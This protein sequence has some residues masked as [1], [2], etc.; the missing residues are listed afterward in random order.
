MKSTFLLALITLL[1]FALTSCS[2][3]APSS[4][5]TGPTL[6]TTSPPV[7][8][9]DA[10]STAAASARA[11]ST[12]APSTS[13][14]LPTPTVPPTPTLPALAERVQ[15]FAYD[16]QVPLQVT[17]VRTEQRDG[18]TVQDITYSTPISAT[19]SAY[20][21]V[22]PGE[23]PFAG[24]VFAHWYAPRQPNGNR[25]EFLDEAVQLA[26]QGVVSLLPEG[27]FPWHTYPTG[28]AQ[29]RDLVVQQVVALR[30][31]VDVLVA[32]DDVDP[33]RLGYVGHDYGA[34]YGTLLAAADKRP[35]AY[36]LMAGDATFYTWFVAYLA[37]VPEDQRP[38]YQAALA[39]VDPINLIG[40]AAPAALLFQFGTYDAFVPSDV[41][42]A[43]SMAAS[44]PKETK[45]YD[46]GHEL[47]DEARQDR[48][49]WLGTHLGF[50]TTP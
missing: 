20:L 46:V 18:V 2:A 24:V 37:Y 36:V 5:G 34:M 44:D 50:S 41:A 9:P 16:Q 8:P 19:T 31:A 38:A 3:A 40:A 32:R 21:V 33:Q 6:S 49:R 47:S 26:K 48:E 7:S 30:R 10:P 17:E 14:L 13:P 12:S 15:L 45:T 29:D 27:V 42:E 1:V 35:Q 11:V 43:L 4:A 39:P 23:G 22:P 25:T 28:T